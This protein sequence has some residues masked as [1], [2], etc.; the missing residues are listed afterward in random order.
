MTLLPWAE[1]ENAPDIG[2]IICAQSDI[3]QFGGKEF[4][5]GSGKR[6]FRMFI[7]RD[8][9]EIKAYI[10]G[11]THFTGT[12]LNPNKVG[13]FLDANDQTLIYCG[14]HGSRFLISTGACVS[15]DC[16]GEGLQPVPINIKDGQITVG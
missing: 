13:N 10:N 8:Y 4:I 6:P 7:L 15:G 16:D 2:T 9:N 5:I 3:P 11:C 12:P 14:V 1:H